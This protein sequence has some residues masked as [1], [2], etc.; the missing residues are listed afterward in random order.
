MSDDL[1]NLVSE[2]LRQQAADLAATRGVA[3]ESVVREA[4]AQYVSVYT[5]EKTAPPVTTAPRTTLGVR[6]RVLRSLIPDVETSPL[7]WEELQREIAEGRG[8]RDH[9]PSYLR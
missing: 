6:L 5:P 2:D 7:G 4:V 8:E 9:A 1:T 3:V